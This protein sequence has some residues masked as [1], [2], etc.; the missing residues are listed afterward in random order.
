V[1]DRAAVSYYV[2]PPELRPFGEVHIGQLDGTAT[3]ALVPGRTVS[4]PVAMTGPVRGIGL[5]SAPRSDAAAP[6]PPVSIVLR[7]ASGA[8]VARGERRPA[9]AERPGTD[10]ANKGDTGDAWTVP[11]AAEDVAPGTRLT[12]DI[13]L[14]GSVPVAVAASLDGRPALTVI[15][16]ADDG[17]RLVW[18]AQTVIY[19]RTRAVERAGWASGALR[20]DQVVLDAPG[21]APDSHGAEV[22]WVE[23]G[24]D[25]MV[26]SVRAEGAGYLVLADALQP[27]WRV[28]VDGTPATSVPADHA[29]VAVALE[30]GQH[31]VR[32]HYPVPWTGAGAW[33]TLVTALAL[34]GGLGV[35]G[36]R[37]RGSHVGA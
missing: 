10:P 18:T 26:L 25:A 27:G 32:W 24:L 16:P 4:T 9:S 34:L 31:T 11:L 12:A 15:T 30:P 37:G 28:T 22:T 36:W 19:E 7:D 5:T 3:T 20:P 1:L 14:H 2:A 29:F 17:L 35:E 21:P 6:M 23:D 33:I 8:V 13:T